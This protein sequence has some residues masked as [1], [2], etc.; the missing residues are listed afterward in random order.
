MDMFLGVSVFSG[1]H[2]GVTCVT[3]GSM[4]A[5]SFLVP[6]VTALEVPVAQAGCTQ[7]RPAPQL[8]ADLA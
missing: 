4:P 8:C 6:T 5:S 2:R 3:V 1:L 7:A